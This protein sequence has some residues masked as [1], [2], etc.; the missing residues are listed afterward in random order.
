LEAV[1]G[2]ASTL[3]LDAIV[4]GNSQIV[5]IAEKVSIHMRPARKKADRVRNL[6]VEDTHILPK[7]GARRRVYTATGELKGNAGAHRLVRHNRSEVYGSITCIR[8]FDVN[9]DRLGRRELRLFEVKLARD[10][11]GGRQSADETRS[12]H[13]KSHACILQL[14]QESPATWLMAYL[15]IEAVWFSHT[16]RLVHANR[17]NRKQP[18]H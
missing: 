3:R 18:T 6:S 13:S 11:P 1:V 10:L 4:A 16:A 2:K 15:A 14:P 12:N 17:R 5:S 8:G 7:I 9:E